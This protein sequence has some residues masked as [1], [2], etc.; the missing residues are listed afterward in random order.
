MMNKND[1]S[2]K[3]NEFKI[4]TENLI[5]FVVCFAIWAL[6]LIYL[7]HIDIDKALVSDVMK[8]TLTFSSIMFGFFGTLIVQIINL[9][10]K[11]QNEKNNSIT[12]FFEKVNKSEMKFV[13]YLN[14]ISMII[15]DSLSLLV[16]LQGE[17]VPNI[18]LYILSCFLIIFIG[19]QW[20]VYRIFI[21]LLFSN[22]DIYNAHG[23]LNEE[24]AE[25]FN[26][27]LSNKLVEKKPV[28]KPIK[29]NQKRKKS[30]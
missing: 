24:K 17:K 3:H 11:Y 1:E 27:S 15:L 30:E 16:L 14:I 7:K 29:L 9:K 23:Q 26:E 6:L 28:K 12:L 20:R 2:H 18:W 19:N 22:Q 10:S 5:F 13:L 4:V 25:K 21:L 8:S